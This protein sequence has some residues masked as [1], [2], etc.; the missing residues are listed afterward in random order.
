MNI[1]YILPHPDFF[2]HCN[3]VAGHIA[4]AAGVIEAFSLL[5]HKVDI[6]S[7]ADTDILNFTECKINI[8]KPRQGYFGRQLWSLSLIKEVQRLIQERT[9]NLCYSRYSLGFAPYFPLLKRKLIH[10]PLVLEINSFGTQRHNFLKLLERNAYN[11]ADFHIVI[12]EKLKENI[13]L[14]L[15]VNRSPFVLPNGI[16]KS[17]INKK[18]A[19]S[20][21]TSTHRV[22]YAGILKPQYG[23][24]LLIKGH[25]SLIQRYPSMELHIYGDGPFLDN[26]K[27]MAHGITGIHLHGGIPYSDVPAKLADMDVLVYTTSEINE[28]QSPIKMFEYMGSL[29]PIVAAKTQQTRMLIGNDVRGLLFPIGNV[30]CYVEKVSTLLSNRI[31]A[32]EIAMK[33]YNEVLN[34]HIWEKRIAELLDVLES[35]RLIYI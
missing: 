19:H 28:F 15:S 10:I 3:G 20:K 4:H 23:L 1:L 18:G 11:C 34:K 31:T 26:L 12:S 29:T 30:K 21:L 6:L 33:A 5:G 8:V 24:E 9:Y 25:K 22:G 35:R 16:S 7:H 2:N 14:L 17:R 32:S 27:S 13:Q